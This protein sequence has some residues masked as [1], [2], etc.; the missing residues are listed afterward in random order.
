MVS[1][2]NLGVHRAKLLLSKIWMDI[3]ASMESMKPWKLGILGQS[4]KSW[5]EWHARQISASMG[6]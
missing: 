4:K 6:A 5:K 2:L 3:M 1:S